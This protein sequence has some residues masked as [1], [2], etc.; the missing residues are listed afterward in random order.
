MK[1]LS[2]KQLV[3]SAVMLA[4]ASVL[5]LIKVWHMPLGGSVTLLSMLPICILSI[6]YGWKWGLFSAFV[7]SIIQMLMDLGGLMTWGMTLKIWIGCIVFDYILAFTS[8]GLAG[9]FRNK[10][11]WGIVGGIVFALTLRFVCHFISGTIF[12]DIWCPDGWNLFLYSIAYN[13]TFMVPEI[14]FTV[15]GAV[16][17]F[18]VP[19]TTKLITQN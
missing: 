6:K 7:Y 10:G 12:F 14:V 18:K 13:G 17:L 5:S 1:N 11:T 19:Q 3:T 16:A 9:I 2:T 4:L 8:L 15:A